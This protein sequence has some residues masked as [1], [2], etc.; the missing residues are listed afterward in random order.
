MS[1]QSD[2]DKEEA[3]TGKKRAEAREKGQFAQ[4]KDLNT[5]SLLVGGVAA[6]MVYFTQSAVSM[7]AFMQQTLG[8][9]SQPI[10]APLYDAM[11]DTYMLTSLPVMV[12]GLVVAIAFGLAQSKGYFNLE[13]LSEP[14]L[15]NLI[16]PLMGIK[17]LLLTKKAATQF[18]FSCFKIV[19]VGGLCAHVIWGWLEGYTTA[20][21]YAL[22]SI[23]D[24]AKD[25]VMELVM[26]A[27]VAFMIIAIIDFIINW[28]ETE[29][30]LKMSFK[31]IKDEHKSTEGDPKMKGRRMQMARDLVDSRSVKHVA[32]ADVVVV[33]PT[34]YAVAIKYDG[35]NMAAPKIVAKGVDEQAA[36]I[37]S[38]ARQNHIP[39]IPQPPLAR[40][41]YRQVKVGGEVPTDL[42]QAVALVLAHV[43]R[44]KGK[45]NRS[46]A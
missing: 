25:V 22:G 4:S 2:E 12:T 29:Q 14:N 39:V 17:N 6:S 45:N 26:K 31:E 46:A 24:G 43:Y 20:E 19:V 38:I 9:L 27:G 44:R 41:L 40:A 35:S 15:D 16:N 11:A 37:R 33:N 10:G 30:Q 21:A 5:L 32:E 1:D 28:Y 7:T 18:L 34:H 8:D 42:Y 36:R 23:L 13:K 3:P